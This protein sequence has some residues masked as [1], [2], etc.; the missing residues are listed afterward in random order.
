MRGLLPSD[1]GFL[2]DLVGQPVHRAFRL[3]NLL[4]TITSDRLQY[5]GRPN[6]Y[7]RRLFYDVGDDTRLNP[8]PAGNCLRNMILRLL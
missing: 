1:Y 3:F 5:K 7:N 4:E 6:L 2:Y 8:T